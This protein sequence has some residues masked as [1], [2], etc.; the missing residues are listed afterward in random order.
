MNGEN[1]RH[2]LHL[3][4]RVYGTHVTG[5]NNAVVTRILGAAPLDF[6]FICNEH[7]PVDRAETSLL[8][9][10]F[11]ALGI[12]PIVRIPS[13]CAVHAAMALDA[14]ADGIVVPYVETVEDVRAL[15]GAVHYRPI[16]GRQLDEFLAGTRRP[17][18][19]TETFLRRFNRHQYLIIGIESVAAY[20]N[21][22]ALL[23]IRGVDGVFMGPHDLSV[24]LEIPEQWDHPRLAQ[25]IEDVTRRCRAA[26]IGV[27]VHLSSIFP[28]E[29]TRRFLAAG[30]NW[31]LDGADISH[32]R[33][34]L[35]ARRA[36]LDCPPVSSATTFPEIHSCLAPAANGATPTTA[37]QR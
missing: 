36:A 30:M 29:L 21:L 15:V 26:D 5:L 2:C 18:P 23:A 13:P 37:A 6:V 33:D 25:L 1:L 20:E 27:G 32:V 17:A 22:D 16:K 14:G 9:Q 28:L 11:S 4:T 35:H 34:G 7:M 3:G 8:C 24:S 12:S 31:I 10:H 19:E